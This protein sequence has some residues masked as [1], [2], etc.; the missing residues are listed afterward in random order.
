MK[1]F[2]RFA[3]LTLLVLLLNLTNNAHAYLGGFEAADGYAP[4][5]NDVA[6]FN[7]GQYG[8]NAGGGGYVNIPDNTG[9]WQKLQGPLVPASG[10]TGNYAYATGHQYYD[11]TNPGFPNLDQAR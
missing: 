6:T 3:S 5:L 7:A 10:I 4:F 11:R 8:A 2:A 9:L 1:A